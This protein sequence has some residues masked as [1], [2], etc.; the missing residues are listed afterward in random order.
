MLLVVLELAVV[1]AAH[2]YIPVS[3]DAPLRTVV[4]GTFAVVV[5]TCPLAV[6]LV[7]V[8][9]VGRNSLRRFVVFVV[10]VAGFHTRIPLVDA[11]P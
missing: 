11:V 2:P 8:A 7:V 6:G 3:F 10:V 9:V 4:A 5:G 1:A